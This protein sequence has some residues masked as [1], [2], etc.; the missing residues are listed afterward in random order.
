MIATLEMKPETMTEH[1]SDHPWEEDL[2]ALLQDLSQVQE[3]L[4]QVLASKRQ[5]MATGDSRGMRTLQPAEEGLARRLHQCHERRAELLSEAAQQ[6]L[7]G[8]RLG[9][10]A[11]AIQRQGGND[12]SR[13][14]K[15][16]SARMRL[17]QHQ[18]LAN[19]V[20][21]QKALLHVAQMLEI[22]AT[23]GRLQP[24][25]GKEISHHARGSLVDQ[26]A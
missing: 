8:A 6:G 13:D 19:W 15:Q 1:P 14:V 20:V 5:Y 17:L 18:A 21:A 7:P 23:G 24:T 22:I 10:L 26:E 25:Y 12:L 16:S 2:A 9:Q 3:E 4:L 11:T